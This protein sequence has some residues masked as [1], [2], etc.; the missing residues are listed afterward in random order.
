[1]CL[2]RQ[3]EGV[4]VDGTVVLIE[5]VILTWP[6]KECGVWSCLS[7]PLRAEHNSFRNSMSPATDALICVSSTELV[8]FP[9]DHAHT[10]I[11]VHIQC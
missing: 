9:N 4:G 8:H 6:C 2:T 3:I 5:W 7:S 11:S 1:M 10:K